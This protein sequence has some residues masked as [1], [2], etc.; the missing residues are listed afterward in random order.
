MWSDSL[1]R[2][3]RWP[4]V[5]GVALRAYP[6]FAVTPETVTASE[7]ML[8]EP[9][10]NPTLRRVVVDHTDELRRALAGRTRAAL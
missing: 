8:A 9:D 5:Y 3:Q 2:R 6:R 4:A 1:V 7:R 10:L